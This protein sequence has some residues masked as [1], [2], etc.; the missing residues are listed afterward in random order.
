[1]ELGLY[2]GALT[3]SVSKQISDQYHTKVSL[4]EFDKDADAVV[5]LHV[6]GIIS[7]GEIK[8]VRQRLMK[9]ITSYLNAHPIRKG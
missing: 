1:M 2:F 5:R 7:D 3:D 4:P 9:K 8:R 6:R